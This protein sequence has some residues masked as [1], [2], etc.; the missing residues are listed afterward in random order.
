MREGWPEERVEEAQK[1]VIYLHKH[2]WRGSD[3]SNFNY[4]ANAMI[5]TPGAF[6]ARTDYW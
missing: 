2:A 6:L 5:A 3:L 1:V 4:A